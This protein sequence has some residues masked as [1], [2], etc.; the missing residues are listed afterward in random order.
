MQKWEKPTEFPLKFSQK[1]SI[2]V[3]NFPD[4]LKNLPRNIRAKMYLTHYGDSFSDID[5]ALEGF[6]GYAQAFTPYTWKV[7]WYNI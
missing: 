3:C 2:F 5:P 6:A 1:V 7:T 4:E